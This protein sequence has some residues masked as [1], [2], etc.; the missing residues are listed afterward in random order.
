M[1]KHHDETNNSGK[2]EDTHVEKL[3]FNPMMTSVNW[4]S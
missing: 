1:Y 3:N 4:K 2:D